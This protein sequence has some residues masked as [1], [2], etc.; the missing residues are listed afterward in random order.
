MRGGKEFIR[1]S[2]V[3]CEVWGEREAKFAEGESS[4]P[5]PGSQRILLER[6]RD[7]ATICLHANMGCVSPRF[8][9]FSHN[10]D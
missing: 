3:Q 7:V 8:S 1:H 5:S 2:E 4:I 6:P 9:V 10:A